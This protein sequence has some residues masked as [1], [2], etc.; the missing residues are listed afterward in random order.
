M[1]QHAASLEFH[2][3]VAFE[4]TA[5]RVSDAGVKGAVCACVAAVM[6]KSTRLNQLGLPECR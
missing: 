1:N 2:Q 3:I 5:P 4:R 6:C